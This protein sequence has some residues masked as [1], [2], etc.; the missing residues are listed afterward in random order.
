MPDRLSSADLSALSEELASIRRAELAAAL[1]HDLTSYNGPSI[2]FGI[3]LAG[4]VY[5]IVLSAIVLV[6]FIG[7]VIVNLMQASLGA[8]LIEVVSFPFFVAAYA[9]FGAILVAMWTGVLSIITLHVVYAVVRSLKLH[10]SL[11]SLGAVAG[12]LIGFIAVLPLT[13]CL[14]WIVGPGDFWTLVIGLPLGPGLAT[15]LGQAGGAW[16]AL[17]ASRHLANYYNTLATSSPSPV[18]E[19]ADTVLAHD[20]L[21]ARELEGHWQFGL[22]H[23]MWLMVWLSVLLSIIRLSGVSF[24]YAIPLLAGW[25][26]YQ[27]ATLRIGRRLALRLGRWWVDRRARR[28]T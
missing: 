9:A 10:G 22:R 12:G 15:V 2:C 7:F 6:A 8:D 28:S 20:D 4:A 3:M 5:P 14:P 1:R 19:V 11:V 25:S 23:L 21:A 18:D 17:R 26:L 24:S 13:V 27:W 16:G